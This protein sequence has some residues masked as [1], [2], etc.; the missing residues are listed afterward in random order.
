[1]GCRQAIRPIELAPE[2]WIGSR[3]PSKRGIGRRD[4]SFRVSGFV[5]SFH[6]SWCETDLDSRAGRP[7][8]CDIR[9]TAKARRRESPVLLV[10]GAP[11][12][13]RTLASPPKSS[14]DWWQTTSKLRL[15]RSLVVL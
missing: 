6:S 13:I 7:A 2:S 3:R 14:A 8:L 4:P 12:A 9:S 11:E 1:P 10:I 5:G 15:L